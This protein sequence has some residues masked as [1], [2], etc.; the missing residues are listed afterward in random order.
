MDI[1]EAVGG[2]TTYEK[3]R[4]GMNCNTHFRYIKCGA[5]K[6][7]F[8][9]RGTGTKLHSEVSD[10]FHVYGAWWKNANE[11]M[12]YA[13]D[14]LFD[15][16]QIRTDISEKPFDRPMKINMVTETY[17]WQPPPSHEDLLNDDINT[18]YYDWV[19]S[20]LLVPVEQEVEQAHKYDHI[21]EEEVIVGH[22]IQVNSSNQSIEI[23]LVYSSNTY[24][25]LVIRVLLDGKVIN[26]SSA[27]LL[28]GYGNTSETIHFSSPLKERNVYTLEASF[29]GQKSAIE[30]SL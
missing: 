1:Q 22:D 28:A 8:I 29:E 6:E 7:E 20:Y 11:V 23:P 14:Q 16:V 21:F 25:S 10:D 9:S 30:F 18:A 5:T 13:N 19:R 27:K 17:N 4:N 24:R 2:G 26:T 12:F 15:T 3:F